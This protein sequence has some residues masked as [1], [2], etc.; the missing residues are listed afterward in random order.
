MKARRLWQ[1]SV[2]G[3]GLN[4][5]LMSVLTHY[6]S[7]AQANPS[8]YYVREGT[9]GD[10]LSVTTP[11]SSVQYAIHLA[12]ASG[13]E[14]RV[15]GGTYTED[16]AITHSV[17]LRGGWNISFTVQNP[18]STPTILYGDAF[19]HNVRVNGEP[20]TNITIENLTLRNGNDGIH[21]SRGDVVVE[22][23]TIRDSVEQGLEINGG[24]VLI[25]GTRILTARQGIEVNSGTVHA[26]DVYIAHTSGEGLLIE[27]GSTITITESTIED[28]LDQGVQVD[29]GSLWL[30]DSL[31]HNTGADGIHAEG[32]STSIVSSTFHTTLADGIRVSGTHVISG[33]LVYEIPGQGIYAQGYD[34]PLFLINNTVR[35]A[36]GD[37]IRADGRLT[38]TVQGNTVYSTGQHGVNATGSTIAVTSNA[39]S[40]CRG[41]GVR[42]SGGGSV[43][44]AANWILSN[45]IGI[46]VYGPTMPMN[47]LT[48]SAVPVFTIA[49]NM[50]GDHITVS[51]ELTGTGAAFVAHNT[52]VGDSLGRQGTGLAVL[53]PLTVTAV[54][55][56]VVSH[57]VGITAR[58]G[59]VLSASHTLL[60]GNADDPISGTV[61]L[62]VP[63]LFVAPAQQNYHLH[64]QSL[65]VDAGID[66]GI[67]TDV[68]GD[69]RSLDTHPDIGADEVRI[70]ASYLPLILKP[71]PPAPPFAP[72][73]HLRADRNDLD[74][75]AQEPY[76]DET[77]P[78]TFCAASAPGEPRRRCWDVDIRYRGDTARTMPKKSWKVFFPSSDP[79]QSQNG[80]SYELNLNADYVDQALLRSHIGYDLFA[81]VGVPTPCAGYARLYINDEY[82][83]LFSEIEQVDERFLHHNGIEMHG[84]LYK[85]FYGRLDLEADDWWYSYHYPKKTNRQSGHEDLVTLIELIN[86]T[87]DEQFPGAIAEVLDVNNW[88]D[89]Y[90]V[91]T[92]IG[93]FEMTNKNYYIYH[94]FSSARWMILP[95]DVD[96]SFGHNE[97]NPYGL[98]DRDISWDNPIDIGADPAGK[99]NFLIERMMD[100]PEFR[101]YHCRL[102]TE[103]MADDF[104]PA[105]MF[106]RI[107]KT[108]A[109]IY[110]AAIADPNRWRP[111]LE[112]YPGFEDGPDELK[113]YITNRI[114]FLEGEMIS[115]CPT[116]QIPLTINELMADNSST[117][118]DEGGDYDGWIE[119][120]NHSST[121]TWDL[122]EMYLTDISSEPT[123]WR[124]PHDTLIP[125]GGTLLFWTDGEESEGPLHASFTLDAGGG[126]IGLF[127]RD[128]YGNAAISVLSYGAQSADV[129]YG[130]LPDG[131]ETFQFFA[132]PTPGWLNQGQPPLI[133][134]TAHEPILPNGSDTV[135]VTSKITDEATVI[136]TLWYRASAP[137]A[138]PPDYQ[139]TQMTA[140]GG[141]LYTGSIPARADGTWVE[142]HVEAEDVVGMVSVDRPGWPQ[143]DYRYIVGW[144]RPPIY[145]NELMAIN[146]RTQ[147]DEVGE[148]DDWL[149]LYNAGPVA[150]DVGGMYLSDNIDSATS[151][152]IP[153][154]TIIPAGGYL[155]LWADGDGKG[156]HLNFKLSGAGEY[157]GLFDSQANYYSP[158]DAVYFNPQTADISWGRFPD[159]S[160]KWHAM[161][162][163]TP[164]DPNRLLPPEFPQVTR[165][166]TWPDTG[167]TVTITA[168][169][170]AGSPNI[171]AT[172]W[173]DAGSSFQAIPMTPVGDGT[174]WQAFLPAQ[175]AGTIV[176]Y[177]LEAVD[178][179]GQE[180]LH[181]PAAP[182]AMYRYK[183]GYTPPSVLINEFL[184]ANVNVNQDEAGE[185]DD[186]IE[187]YNG[188]AVTVTLD[189]MHLT[190][191]L[192]EPAKWQFP[193]GT[194][195][196][197]GNYLLVWCDRGMEQGPLHA[198]FKLNRDGEVIGL[199]D[200]VAHDLVPLDWIA[201][202]PQ[203]TDVSYGR[204]PDGADIWVSL[205]LPTPGTS[206][207]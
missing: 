174:T 2:L 5:V 1:A 48:A 53:G 203:Q 73:Y 24:T 111:E 137:G 154:G 51:V 72:I 106:P 21:I 146:S 7:R 66:A 187:L 65:A 205:T 196:P 26:A 153:A 99:H 58:A 87:P 16:L 90:A 14:V 191:D 147:E 114:E 94:D 129:S 113:T 13:D 44:I 92:L 27:T 20:P 25:S 177:Y 112:G 126:Q 3:V 105:E 102:L 56:I 131:G 121:L 68:D 201:F 127:D 35:D 119:I 125:P 80:I 95:W 6:A 128:V 8:I 85:P 130:R 12:V 199:F 132:T 175:S 200:T 192:A 97:G 166:P 81:R 133:S 61:A 188:G 60:W 77:I 158:I 182:A 9:A 167:E 163:P 186:W 15:A 151:Y 32:G 41:D 204:Q 78:A 79:F 70:H 83:G 145:I 33:N 54:N 156:V 122:G 39:V 185:Y 108:Y 161:A 162:T 18:V 4:V 173:Y 183:V 84:N 22:S 117:I 109:Q 170:T 152:M 10:C 45:L 190:D 57:S 29:R 74:W 104:S 103:M 178:S 139:S 142:Y 55:N 86:N 184:A 189:G 179:M 93:N 168:I 195:I 30:F 116:L 141:N 143:G 157:V 120:H 34:E 107:D 28:C 101:F 181:P 23:C 198:N 88:L 89:W 36:G 150:I 62:H 155:I 19:T 172:L 118:A 75:L 100:M 136:A 115:F 110:D 37:G 96:I 43:D 148:T 160:D 180:T 91:N 207:E 98:F 11:C 64:P 59:A 202:D 50:I 164:G 17:K 47:T 71:P 206:N 42:A 38:V 165:T 69:P 76:R 46:A 67:F 197:P 194:T 171:S 140:G 123:K 40:Q 149:E 49:N 52:L 138:Q 193:T 124:I 169:I 82:Y 134:G 159:G 63:P 135:N 144:H 176:Q 31:I